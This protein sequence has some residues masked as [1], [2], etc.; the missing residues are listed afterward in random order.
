MKL[1]EMTFNQLMDGYSLA[2]MEG[3]AEAMKSIHTELLN[4]RGSRQG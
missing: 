3:D 1:S 2:K 4:R